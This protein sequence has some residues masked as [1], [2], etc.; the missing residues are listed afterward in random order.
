MATWKKFYPFQA[1]P[2]RF[3]FEQVEIT[4]GDDVAFATAIGHCGHIEHG[5]TTD[6]KFRSRW[7]FANK[8]AS[9]GYFT[10]II[11]YLRRT[12]IRLST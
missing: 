8:R 10:N 9:G 6:L 5:E 1:K 3:G 4:A 7:A 12:N 11:H 2:V